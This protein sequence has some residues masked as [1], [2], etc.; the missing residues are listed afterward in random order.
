MSE[1]WFWLAI[2]FTGQALFSCRFL[3][4]WIVSERQKQSII[5]RAFW[6]FSMAGGITLLCYALYKADPV[7]I[8]GQGAG[9]LIYSRNLYF[10]FRGPRAEASG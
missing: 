7:F 1:E 3:I 10:I 6:Y 8:V 2:G 9:I 4:Q 5:P